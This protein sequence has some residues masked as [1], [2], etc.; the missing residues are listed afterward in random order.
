MLL[1]LSSSALFAQSVTTLFTSDN[2]FRGN[3]FDVVST[4]SIVINSF[5]CNLTN[6]GAVESVTVYYKL[7]TSVGFEANAAAWTLLGTDTNVVSNGQDVPT[8]V[9]VGG[10]TLDAG[11][12]YGFYFD[13][14]SYVDGAD[15]GPGF[16]SNTDGAT[17][18]RYTNGGPNM[19][20]DGTVTITTNSGQG[21]PPFGAIFFPRQWNGTIYYE[22]ANTVPTMSQAM[23]IAF[24]VLVGLVAMFMVARRRKLHA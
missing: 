14:D 11:Q 13:L 8:P 4:D 18:L 20:S 6:A 17:S 15:A 10:L 24:S 23:L 3:T 16:D 1:L 22:L 21:D 9:N 7:G 5:D 12:V 19:Y 2:Q